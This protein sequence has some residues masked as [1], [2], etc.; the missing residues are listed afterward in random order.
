MTSGGAL[1]VAVPVSI[2]AAASFAV[3]NVAQM[4]AR[5]ASGD[6]ENARSP[7]SRPSR[8]RAALAGRSRGVDR[9]LRP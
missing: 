9:R 3:A 6:N 7:P 8:S 4:R 2:G 5:P 1:I